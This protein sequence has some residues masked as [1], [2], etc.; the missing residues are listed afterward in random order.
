MPTFIQGG[1][2]MK[3]RVNLKW[4]FLLPPIAGAWLSG[5]WPERLCRWHSLVPLLAVL[6]L[7][8]LLIKVRSAKSPILKAALSLVCAGALSNF[9]VLAAN[10]GF[11]PV[12][13]PWSH[14]HGCWKMAAATDN[15]LFLSDRIRLVGQ[16]TVMEQIG[17]SLPDWP[18]MFRIAD[19]LMMGVMT[20]S[21]GDLLAFAAFIIFA[22][23]WIIT[24]KLI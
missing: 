16:N 7:G 14:P 6:L 23:H 11:M 5:R 22:A 20:A 13:D 17:L 21:V 12:I 4:V 3:T 2:G 9:A 19:I 10:H 1:I 24:R 18:P 8:G 15:L